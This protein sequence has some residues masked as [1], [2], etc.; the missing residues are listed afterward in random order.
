[1]TR[2]RVVRFLL[3]ILVG[4]LGGSLGCAGGAPGKSL[5]QPSQVIESAEGRWRVAVFAPDPPP[6][7]VPF[8]IE[9]EIEPTAEPREILSS[10]EVF[11]D[12]GMPHHQHGML[13]IPEV[14]RLGPGRY[15]LHG[16]E[17]FMEGDWRITIDITAGNHT[18]RVR[19]WV[20]PE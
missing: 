19:W 3:P 6:L 14:D 15:R 10:I 7:D 8:S 11:A 18:E 4:F 9:I 13:G 16:F 17:L 20:V 12:G 2:R 1:M 5:V